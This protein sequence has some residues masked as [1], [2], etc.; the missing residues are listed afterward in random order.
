M[1]V[2][3]YRVEIDPNQT[4]AR[5]RQAAREFDGAL[6]RI[7]ESDLSLSPAEVDL[8]SALERFTVEVN[9][10]SHFPREQS[11]IGL[12]RQIVDSLQSMEAA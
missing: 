9:A 12:S 6:A 10:W 4:P 1:A 11:I 7:L 3:Q 2:L 8:E 5:V